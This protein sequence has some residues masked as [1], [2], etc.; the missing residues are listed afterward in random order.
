MTRRI[1]IALAM[2]AGLTGCASAQPGGI[3]GRAARIAGG[4]ASA[5]APIGLQKEIEIGRGIAAT[6][7]GRWG[8]VS[9]ESLNEYVNLVGQVVAQQSPRASELTYRFAV[10]DTDEVNAFAAPGGYVFVTRGAL[11]LM[12]SESELAAL[13]GH[14]IAHVDLRHIVRRIQRMSTVQNLS[15]EFELTGPILDA[16]LAEAASTLFTGL[17]RGDELASDSLGMLYATA[18]GY[19]ADGMVRFLER[20]SQGEQQQRRGFAALR[21]THPPATMRLEAVQAD[22]AAFNLDMT[23]GPALEARFR[24]HV[25]RPNPPP[26]P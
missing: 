15:Q 23:A 19:R 21:T 7:A 2:V 6:V 3:L 24:Q 11:D 4:V 1:L 8:L 12:E 9:D 5:R 14:E 16:V 22:A 20:M 17:E 18:A 25:P 26:Q 10:L 13:L